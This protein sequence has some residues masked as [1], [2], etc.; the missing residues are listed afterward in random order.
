MLA[1][2]LNTNALKAS[3][4]GLTGRLSVSRVRAAVSA[5]SVSILDEQGNLLS[6]TGPVSPEET[7]R[8][9]IQN[10]ELQ[11]PQLEL[12]PALAEGGTQ[13]GK[14]EGKFFVRLPLTG[15]TKQSLVFEFPCG[16]LLEL[17]NVLG[18]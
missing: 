13:T 4:S 18:D 6:T 14:S 11:Q 1:W 15:N 9:C 8:A 5:G 7:F 12:Y 3:S 10:L 2:I 16:K 17:Y